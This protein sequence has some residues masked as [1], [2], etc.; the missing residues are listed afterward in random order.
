MKRFGQL[1][2]L[3]KKNLF[4][5]L[6]LLTT[7]FSIYNYFVWKTS[8]YADLYW[9]MCNEKTNFYNYLYFIN[10]NDNEEEDEYFSE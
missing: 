6:N 2:N 4:F 8:N 7:T 9:Y 3:L 5:Y 1:W 10:L